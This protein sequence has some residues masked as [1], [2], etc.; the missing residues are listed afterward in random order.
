M[1]G[2]TGAWHG[3]S[4]LQVVGASP[5]GEAPDRE[6][7][8]DGHGGHGGHGGSAGGA[9]GAAAAAG[10]R[11]LTRRRHPRPAPRRGRNALRAGSGPRGHGGRRAE[12]TPRVLLTIPEAAARYGLAE[13]N[14][15]RW[16]ASQGLPGAARLGGRWYLR[17]A[18]FERWLA[19]EAVE[20]TAARDGTNTDG[21]EL[22]GGGGAA[23]PPRSTSRPSRPRGRAPPR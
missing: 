10:G 7:G 22:V 20:A 6:A 13:S 4:G 5:D 3:R 1:T 15:Y 2:T 19:G 21:P 12:R 17:T 18:A 14:L 8:V 9:G 16:L 23:H 11:L